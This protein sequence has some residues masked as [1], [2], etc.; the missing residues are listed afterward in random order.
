MS[1][2][3]QSLQPVLGKSGH[4]GTATLA[5]HSPFAAQS[6][7]SIG[8]NTAVNNSNE[9]NT[10]NA[11]QS[12]PHLFSLPTMS[13][14]SDLFKKLVKA[15]STYDVKKLHYVDKPKQRRSTLWTGYIP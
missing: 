2:L 3:P 8:Q 1:G 15:A 12:S 9:N 10:I 7:A 13:T 4:A 11:T 6:Q 14:A 5:F